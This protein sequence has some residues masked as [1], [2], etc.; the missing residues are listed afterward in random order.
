MTTVL[1]GLAHSL[2]APHATA[3]RRIAAWLAVALPD[4]LDAD[5]A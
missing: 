5:A 4:H 1:D 3:R 2:N